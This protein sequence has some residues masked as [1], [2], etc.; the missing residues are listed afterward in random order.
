MLV[1][2]L[3]SLLIIFSL[4]AVCLLLFIQFKMKADDAFL[5]DEKNF[6]PS[7]LSLPKPK[8]TGMRAIVKCSPKRQFKTKRLKYAG[9]TD[10]RI[11]EDAYGTEN[12]CDY[13]CAGYGTCISFCPQEAIIIKNH[14]AVITSSCNGCGQCVSHCPQKLIEL[15]PVE[16]QYY[17]QCAAAG[18]TEINCSAA[19]S[20]CTI[21]DS[22]ETIIEQQFFECPTGALTKL[23]PE[24]NKVFK[25]WVFLYNVLYGK[26]KR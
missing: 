23:N 11:F 20:N 26:K 12:N 15:I 9:M 16:Q 4:S 18:E 19:C 10:C 17:R 22:S 25:F 13:G 24:P 1:S 8:A 7:C 6:I 3:V 14:T 5:A 2:I 21:C